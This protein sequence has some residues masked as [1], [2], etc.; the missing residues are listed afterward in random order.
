LS[1]EAKPP[2]RPLQPP[3]APHAGICVPALGAKRAE[4]GL[5]VNSRNPIV[6]V[7]TSEE[8]RF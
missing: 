2:L 8:T 1:N 5:L 3:P 4:L 6:T 7:E